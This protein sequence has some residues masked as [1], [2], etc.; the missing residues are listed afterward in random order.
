MSDANIWRPGSST[1][2]VNA[3]STNREQWFVSTA[4]QQNFTLTA[5][6]YVVGTQSLKVYLNGVK[7]LLGK[8]FL[9]VDSTHFQM[10]EALEAGED[11][12]AEGIIGSTGAVQA[13]VSAANAL[14]S[15][16]AA[17]ASLATTL[18][19]E[20]A[21]ATSAANAATS[22]FLAAGHEIAAQLAAS[23]AQAFSEFGF[24]SSAVAY[25]LGFVSDATVLFPTDFGTL[26]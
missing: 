1:P 25:D 9:E 23:D 6:Q 21:A 5:F 4:A 24:G 20:G 3:N 8:D 15:E 2:L 22:E 7:Q 11:V 12:F 19:S 17:A 16:V 18:V 14:V 26:P 13:E 10:L